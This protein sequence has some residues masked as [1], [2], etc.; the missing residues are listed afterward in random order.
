[1]TTAAKDLEKEAIFFGLVFLIVA[2]VLYI[3]IHDGCP[4]GVTDCGITGDMLVFSYLL[5]V[6]GGILL[7]AGTASSIPS[8]TA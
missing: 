1:M 4:Q 6:G 3:Y 2:A 7:V 5:A 8:R